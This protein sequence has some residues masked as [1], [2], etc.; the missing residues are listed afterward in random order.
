MLMSIN[1]HINNKSDA[2]LYIIPIVFALLSGVITSPPILYEDL[3]AFYSL[4]DRFHYLSLHDF[5]VFLKTMPDW[6]IYIYMYIFCKIGIPINI[7]L[8]LV[9][10]TTVFMILKVSFL[11]LDTKHKTIF[12][13]LFIAS[14]IVISGLLSGVRNLH[15]I[16]F[17]FY[18]V[19]FFINN[20]K[21]KAAG[22]YIISFLVHFSSLMYVGVFP[23]MKL[24]LKTIY[25]VWLASFIGF[26]LPIILVPYMNNKMEYSTIL[27][28]N[29]IQHYIL[30]KDYYYNLTLNDAKIIFAS[31]L[32][33][34]WYP[35]MLVFLF[36]KFK[37]NDDSKWL[38]LLF[39]LSIMMNL[40]VIQLTVFERVSFFAKIIFV[41]CFLEDTVVDYKIKK[42]VFIYFLFLFIIQL[43]LYIKGLLFL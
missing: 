18:A 15:S 16:A 34:S 1:K 12:S 14:S 2:L 21:I 11:I 20:K 8:G 9:T 23:L 17:V 5:F 30:L 13:Y 4:Y 41:V 24:K 42:W 19:Y 38:Q 43:A 29:K 39:I 10:F 37:K 36:F 3:Y 35:I 26:L 31:I 27:I 33:F 28:I 32:K 7:L 40:L 6:L 22:Y 25:I